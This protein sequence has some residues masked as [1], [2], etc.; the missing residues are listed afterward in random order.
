YDLRLMVD[1]PSGSA[2]LIPSAY[3]RHSDTFINKTKTHYSFTQYMTTG[4]FDCID[5]DHR[6]R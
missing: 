6:V 2:I 3:L 5:D 4:L 1:F